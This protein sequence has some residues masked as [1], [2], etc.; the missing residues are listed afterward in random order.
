M[1]PASTSASDTLAAHLPFAVDD[2]EAANAAFVRW[3]TSQRDSDLEP[4]EIW[5]YCYARDYFAQKFLRN[6]ALQPSDYDALVTKAFTAVKK[7]HASVRD[8]QRF[9]HWVS[10]VYKHTY[11]R[12]VSRRRETVQLEPERLQD[13]TPMTPWRE[14][15]QQVIRRAVRAALSRLPD[16][17][18]QV[19]QMRLVDRLEYEDISD[20]TGHAVPTVRA[21]VC[22]VMAR[23]REDPDILAI[24]DELIE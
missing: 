23:L 2:Y 17:L 3:H 13:A 9:A 15:D 10:V 7:Y 16:F 1:L 5:A 21:Y 6:A 19:A 11:L 4:V 24:R 12:Y 14:H 22:K 18:Q 20:R 8:P